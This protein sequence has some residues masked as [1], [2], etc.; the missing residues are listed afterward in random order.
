MDDITQRVN[1]AIED[2]GEALD[3]Q[4]GVDGELSNLKMKKRDQ[5]RELINLDKEID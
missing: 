2:R 4:I 5:D 1:Q 3:A